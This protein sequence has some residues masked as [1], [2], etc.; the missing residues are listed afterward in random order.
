MNVY[1]FVTSY[2]NFLRIV[3]LSYLVWNL[4]FFPF[5]NILI[6]NFEVM[7]NKSLEIKN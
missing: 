1:I 2:L 4:V 5:P 7:Q 3:V 6:I